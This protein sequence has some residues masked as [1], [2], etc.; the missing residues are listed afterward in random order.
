MMRNSEDRMMNQ[1]DRIWT[2]PN[3]MSAARLFFVVPMLYCLAHEARGWF[4]FWVILG[5]ASDFLDGY[6]A[7][8][9]DQQS[10]LGRMID[11]LSDKLNVVLV[12][13]FLVHS[14][15]YAFPLWFF[16][17]LLVRELLVLTA[18]LWFRWKHGMVPESSGPG[19]Y[20]AFFTGICVLMYALKL[21]PWASVL[22]WMALLLTVY[23]TIVY[24]RIFRKQITLDRKV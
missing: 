8:R 5:I 20:S 4:V 13:G 6:I 12:S 7:R 19:K 10:N 24:Y 16:V 18:G 14:R 15:L 1:R 17:F 9:F 21:Q 22:M 3:A 23:S 11:P 2:V